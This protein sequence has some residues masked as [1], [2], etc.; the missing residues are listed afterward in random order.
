MKRHALRGKEIY[1]EIVRRFY[2]A[3]FYNATVD[4]PVGIITLPD[5][6]GVHHRYEVIPRVGYIN[7][8][9]GHAPFSLIEEDGAEW[10]DKRTL[11]IEEGGRPDDDDWY[12]TGVING[13]FNQVQ[14]Q[15]DEDIPGAFSVTVLTE[16]CKK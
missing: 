7:S 11:S 10:T 4:V 8:C 6:D 12:H 9:A 13:V 1:M 16:Y 3:V 15:W 14:G 2:E 5:A